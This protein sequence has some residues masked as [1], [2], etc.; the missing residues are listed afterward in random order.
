MQQ[1]EGIVK[2]YKVFNSD[3]TCGGKQYSCPGKFEED[4]KLLICSR[5]MHFCKKAVD[6]FNY[7]D[8]NPDFHVAEVVAYGR[9]V[10]QDDKCVTDKLEII[11]EIPWS[12]VLEMVNVGK[13]CTGYK[14]TGNWNDG[15][16]NTGNRNTGGWNAGNYNTG[17]WN[18]GDW[19][20]GDRNTGNCNTGDYN[21]G[22]RNTGNRNTGNCNSGDW[23]TGYRN[24]GNYNAGNYNTGNR[25]TGNYN[26]GDKNTGYRNAGNY[27]AGNYNTG[28]RN[29]GDWNTGD[30][31]AT[32]HSTGCFNTVE[33]KICLFDKPSDWTYRD[34]ILSDARAILCTMPNKLAWVDFAD[35]TADEKIAC[36][37][38]KTTDGYL[39][40]YSVSEQTERVN[41]WWR[42]L[43]KEKQESVMSMPNFDKE[44]FKQITGIDVDAER[45]D[46]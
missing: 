33:Q 37:D 8:F 43:P 14:N 26:T 21:T 38:A 20:D 30:W 29:S 24:D 32:D 40:E 15:D 10:E 41:R 25:N 34:W 31:N 23:N 1:E 17:D 42:S 12:K 22:D 35:M 11:R 4:V 46:D 9:V 7:Y 45:M 28:N 13:A 2:G 39:K 6:C 44:I 27:N 36:P 18:D 16:R 3:W 19:N 5:G